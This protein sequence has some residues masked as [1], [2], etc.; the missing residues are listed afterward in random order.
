M[1]DTIGSDDIVFGETRHDAKNV[2]RLQLRVGYPVRVKSGIYR[3]RFGHVARFLP[4]GLVEIRLGTCHLDVL[5]VDLEPQL[6][7]EG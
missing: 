2:A 5:E 6:Q 4:F 7:M 3:G 1:N